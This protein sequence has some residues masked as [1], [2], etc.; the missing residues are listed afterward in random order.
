MAV[1]CQMM[2]LSELQQ[3]EHAEQAFIYAGTRCRCWITEEL[4]AL[5]IDKCLANP[6]SWGSSDIHGSYAMLVK[7]ILKWLH[8]SLGDIWWHAVRPVVFFGDEFIFTIFEWN[9][10]MQ[11]GNIL[12]Y[13]SDFSRLIFLVHLVFGDKSI[14]NCA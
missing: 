12:A 11:S 3:F 6:C 5:E 7:S 14:I 13:A 10:L 2:R 9:P 8:H 1:F 4:H